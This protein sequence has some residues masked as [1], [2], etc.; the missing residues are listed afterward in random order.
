M[1]KL[2]LFKNTYKKVF[3]GQKTK[4]FKS[5]LMSFSQNLHKFIH[6]SLQGSPDCRHCPISRRLG[7]TTI[8]RKMLV[9]P[10]FLNVTDEIDQHFVSDQLLKDKTTEKHKQC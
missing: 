9:P 8:I 3:L 4:S 7:R 1:D 5:V 10:H 2:T 6:H